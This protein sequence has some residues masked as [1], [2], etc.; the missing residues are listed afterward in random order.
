MKIGL[1]FVVV[2]HQ[3]ADG[4]AGMAAGVW[5]AMLLTVAVG[6]VER[7]AGSHLPKQLDSD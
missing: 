6:A 5:P 3:P 2:A 1:H 7:L 4:A